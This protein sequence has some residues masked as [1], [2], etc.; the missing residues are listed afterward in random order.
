MDRAH[1]EIDATGRIIVD[2]SRLYID[3]ANAGVNQFNDPGA[4]VSV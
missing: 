2:T 1:M 4:F 3:D